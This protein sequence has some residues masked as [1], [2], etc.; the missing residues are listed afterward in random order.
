MSYTE[1]RVWVEKNLGLGVVPKLIICRNKRLLKGDYL[2]DDHIYKDFEG[3]L[4]H[5]GSKHY[6][7]WHAVIK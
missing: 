6:P 7:N 4:L 2:I 3:E 1:K 5:F